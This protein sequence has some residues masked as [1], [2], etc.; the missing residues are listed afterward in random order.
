M[1]SL[2]LSEIPLA[3]HPQPQSGD[4]I[5]QNFLSEILNNAQVQATLLYLDSLYFSLSVL[6]HRSNLGAFRFRE[7]LSLSI[8]KSE[9]LLGLE[10]SRGASITSRVNIAWL[11]LEFTFSLAKYAVKCRVM[12]EM[13]ES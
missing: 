2:M 5:G 12:D 7:P 11:R 9:A 1:L 13:D 8:Q 6:A 4:A 10:G 3:I